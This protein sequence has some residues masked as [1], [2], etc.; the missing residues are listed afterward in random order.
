[1][2]KSS[3]SRFRNFIKK[4]IELSHY[5]WRKLK[6]FIRVKQ[7]KKGDVITCNNNI[8]DCLFFLNYGIVTAKHNYSDKTW[9]IFYNDIR[10]KTKLVEKKYSHIIIQDYCSY[11]YQAKS[12]ITFCVYEDCEVLQ[13]KYEDL[14]YFFNKY[15]N[16]K[17]FI[18][19][20]TDIEN[21][22]LFKQFD[23]QFRN[24]DMESLAIFK[25]DNKYLCKKLDDSF[26]SEYLNID[27]IQL[28][29]LKRGRLPRY[30]EIRR[31]ENE[32][33]IN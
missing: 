26:I 28:K 27:R 30:S 6:S 17:Y 4:D 7:Y 1:M 11:I 20:I 23:E 8:S 32:S 21:R 29:V 14:Q 9:F 3:Y 31:K 5:Q 13:I 25:H 33:I 10:R 19:L 16:P 24:D 18:K 2:Y 12:R 15:Y 22:R